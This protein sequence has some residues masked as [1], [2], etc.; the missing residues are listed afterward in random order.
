MAICFI[1][2]RENPR[3]PDI[4]TPIAHLPLTVADAQKNIVLDMAAPANGWTQF[5]LEAAT[6]HLASSELDAF[7]G[8]E[9]IGSTE[10]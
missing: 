1:V 3:E 9:W 8:E 2:D 10:V 7:L 5:L 4:L 6:A